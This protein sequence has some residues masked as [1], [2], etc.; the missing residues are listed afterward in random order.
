MNINFINIKLSLDNC[1]LD[2]NMKGELSIIIL[3]YKGDSDG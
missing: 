2:S 3:L 1:L